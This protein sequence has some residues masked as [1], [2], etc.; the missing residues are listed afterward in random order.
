MGIIKNYDIADNWEYTL[1]IP[2]RSNIIKSPSVQISQTI[3]AGL[4]TVKVENS[5]SDDAVSTVASKSV[6]LVDDFDDDGFDEDLTGSSSTAESNTQIVYDTPQVPSVNEADIRSQVK[7]ELQTNF[8]E[9]T[10]AVNELRES[11]NSV[12][13]NAQTKLLDFAMILAEKII[14]KRI[15]MDPSVV[16]D[17]VSAA[18][19]KISG[20]DQVTFKVNPDDIDTI[21]QFQS[22][23]EAKL[24]GLKKLVILPDPSIDRGGVIIETNV[25]YVDATIKQQMNVLV[26]TIQELQSQ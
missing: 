9:L 19:E 3:F 23:I 21:N 7:D 22:R 12:I 1:T 26:R 17:V 4:G 18:M 16:N 24:V 8:D 14:H 6:D 25:G 11:R 20:A 10:Q 13:E 2:E 15:E 5:S